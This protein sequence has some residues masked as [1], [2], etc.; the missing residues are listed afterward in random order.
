MLRLF[1]SLAIDWPPRMRLQHRS[2]RGL[3]AYLALK[4]GPARTEELAGALWPDETNPPRHRVWRAKY[5][6]RTL[7]GDALQ[8]DGDGYR[9]DLAGLCRDVDEIERLRRGDPTLAQLDQALALMDGE[10]LANITYTWADNERRRLY[11]IRAQTLAQVANARLHRNEPI[12]AMTA[13]HELLKIDPL[14]EHG[15]Q[16]AMRADAALG[17]RQA[18]LDRYEYLA[19]ELDVRLG[20]RPSTATR[21][22]YHRLLS[23]T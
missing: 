14:N 3:V 1:G 2:A 5:L 13:A 6:A 4:G 16:I 23:Q 7:L 22:L 17:H 12:E 11:A 18:I 15:W 19:C 9:L 20:L 10:P 8:R 21:D